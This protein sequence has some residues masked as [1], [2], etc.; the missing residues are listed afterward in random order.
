MERA[1]KQAGNLEGVAGFRSF[2]FLRNTRG[3]D[4]LEY[5]AVTT[6]DGA[7]AYEAWRKSESF[8]RAHGEAYGGGPITSTLEL[9]DVLE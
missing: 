6:W 4:E 1:F 9:Y 3:G 5:V 8:A 2:S 7:E